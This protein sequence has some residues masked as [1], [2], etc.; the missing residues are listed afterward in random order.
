M[1]KGLKIAIVTVVVLVTLGCFSFAFAS[2]QGYLLSSN[3]Q[4]AT[5]QQVSQFL[6][7][8]PGV[9]VG[10]FG[11]FMNHAQLSEVTGTVVAQYKG[12]AVLSTTSG[13]V[14]VLLPNMWSYNGQLLN[15][16]ELFDNTFTGT[17]QTVTFK[18]LKGQ[19]NENGFNLNIMVGYEA[20]NFANAHAFAVLPFNIEAITS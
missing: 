4:L 2:S 13:Q 16:T 7:T 15:R 17:G 1:N 10:A 20:V 5:N 19:W 3:D 12:M 9:A 6:K 11:R 8:H 18:V 14:T